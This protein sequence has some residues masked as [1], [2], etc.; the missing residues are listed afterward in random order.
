VLLG[1]LQVQLGAPHAAR[2]D[3]SVGSTGPHAKHREQNVYF[4]HADD[5]SCAGLFDLP[6][7]ISVFANLADDRDKANLRMKARAPRTALRV[8]WDGINV[9]EVL[10]GLGPEMA[11]AADVTVL[12]FLA[13]FSNYLLGLVNLHELHE[14]VALVS[15]PP[16]PVDFDGLKQML[17]VDG[18]LRP[19]MS[20]NMNDARARRSEYY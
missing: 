15:I 7:T 13:D 4:L 6:S 3:S 12:H 20:A 10:H 19:E 16:P 9:D 1:E 18:I 5:I 11:L 8:W 17:V 2:A 14:Y